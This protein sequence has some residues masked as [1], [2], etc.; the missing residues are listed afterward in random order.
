[1]AVLEPDMRS[2][3]KLVH[4]L[5]VSKFH[6]R[7]QLPPSWKIWPGPGAVGTRAAAHEPAAKRND[8][9]KLEIMVSAVE[10]GWG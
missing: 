3:L 8:R 2:T 6:E 9:T 4:L 5:V 1:M 10:K 7:V